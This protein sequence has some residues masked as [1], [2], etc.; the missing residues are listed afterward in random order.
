M[1]SGM[2]TVHIE[3]GQRSYDV[4]IKSGLLDHSGQL[5]SNFVPNKNVAI[6]TNSTIATLYLDVLKLSLHAH[7]FSSREIILSDGEQFKTLESMQVIYEQ[8]AGFDLDR[9]SALIALGGGVIGD[10]AGFAAATFLRGISFFQIPTTL[11]A[12]VD[13]SVGGKTGVNLPGGKNLVGAFYQPAAVIIDPCVLGTLPEP[14]LNAGLAEVIKYGII[15]DAGFFG[16]IENHLN[17]IRQRETDVLSS[18]IMKC[19]R[20]KADIVSRDETEKGVR[21]HLNYGHT[22]GHAVETLTG[23]CGFLHG[24]AVA[25]GMC[26]A[27]QLSRALGFCELPDV[28][29]IESLISSCGL[30][31]RAPVFP[32]ADYMDAMLKDKKKSGSTINCVLLRRIGEVFLYPVSPELLSEHLSGILTS[33]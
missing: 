12:Q 9:A 7:G 33:A 17:A 28:Q 11:L 16:F 21:A 14:E 30:P 5:L 15:R 18:L 4:Y 23:Y 26:A 1:E 3:L 29:R 31:V 8:L 13:S 20:I 32:V 2:H 6:I 27:A 24:E 19:C 10:M 25:I 22:L